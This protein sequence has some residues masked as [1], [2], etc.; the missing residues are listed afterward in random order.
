MINQNELKKHLNYNPETGVFTWLNVSKYSKVNVGDEAGCKDSNG[1]IYITI[2]SRKYSSHRLAWLYV[3]GDL[4]VN[5]IDHLNRIRSDNRICNLRDVTHN[6]NHKNKRNI[7]NGR[8][9]VMRYKTSNKWV[10][11]IRVK[12]KDIYLGSFNSKSEAIRAREEAEIKY[13][14]YG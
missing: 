12:G 2:L 6:E 8:V 1:Y 5:Q 14:F 10:A 11:R 13:D 3:Y 4:P 9:G 7:S